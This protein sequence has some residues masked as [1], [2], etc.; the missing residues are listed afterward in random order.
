MGF[1][2][3]KLDVGKCTPRWTRFYCCIGVF[4]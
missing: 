2:E 4:T 3:I 1:V